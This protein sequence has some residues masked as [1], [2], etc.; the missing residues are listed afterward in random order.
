MIILVIITIV[1]GVIISAGILAGI[2]KAAK[3]C[4]FPI[5][6]G[7]R[8]GVSSPLHSG[9]KDLRD[10]LSELSEELKKS[11]PAK[12][13]SAPVSTDYVPTFKSASDESFI[14]T[15]RHRKGG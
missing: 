5:H 9:L 3:H 13:T 4:N 15:F 6:P 7:L 11:E 8:S 12:P 10:D 14:P 2:E 1:G